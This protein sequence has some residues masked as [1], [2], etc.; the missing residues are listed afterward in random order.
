MEEIFKD[1]I[2]HEGVYQVSNLGNVKSLNYARSGKEKLLK[3]SLNKFNGY[4]QVNLTVN[5]K[6]PTRT[7]HQLVAITFLNHIP[8]GMESVVDH[9]D[10]N[11]GNNKLSNLRV[12]THRGNV[13]RRGGSSSYPGVSWH[14]KNKN[15][16]AKILIKSDRLYLGAFKSEIS[17]HRNY[18]KAL[19]NIELYKGNRKEFLKILNKE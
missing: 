16:M 10:G 6:A 9:I 18:K 2:G 14:K 11:R 7:V 3:Q 5:K 4:L 13:S 17:A 15:W 1:I 12:I 19:E 8:F